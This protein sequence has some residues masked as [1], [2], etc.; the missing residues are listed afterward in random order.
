MY[1]F[2]TTKGVLVESIRGKLNIIDVE[3]NEESY[4]DIKEKI[5]SFSTF[6]NNFISNI[7][8][9]TTLLMGTEREKE[10]LCIF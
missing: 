9:K 7:K 5:K 8:Q 6:F 2:D 1:I 3:F 10:N 4:Q